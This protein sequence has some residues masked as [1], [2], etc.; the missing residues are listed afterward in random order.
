MFLKCKNT[1]FLRE[2]FAHCNVYTDA[3]MYVMTIF[4]CGKTKPLQKR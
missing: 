3:N 2:N 1:G 4:N